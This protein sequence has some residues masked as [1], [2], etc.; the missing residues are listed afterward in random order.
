MFMIFMTGFVVC[1]SLINV[2]FIYLKHI[3]VKHSL[4]SIK[5]LN[6]YEHSQV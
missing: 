5:S 4:I 6:E 3:G 1:I 2:C